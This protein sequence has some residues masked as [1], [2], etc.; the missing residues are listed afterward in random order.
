MNEH[1]RA[2][3]RQTIAEA[4]RLREHA[5]AAGR[6]YSG[7]LLAQGV[8]SAILLILIEALFP[9]GFARYLAIGGWFAATMLVFTW[10][11][12]RRVFP[13]GATRATVVANVVWFGSH[14]LLIG[15][16]VR[17]QYQDSLPVWTLAAIVMSLPFAVAALLLRRANR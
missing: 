17:W 3:S 4:A 1:D 7:Y 2:S 15:P 13:A 5:A 12:R 10:S 14:L 8:A 16:L 6:W 9:D 11:S